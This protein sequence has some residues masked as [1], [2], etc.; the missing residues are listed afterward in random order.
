MT[1]MNQVLLADYKKSNKVRRAKLV[2]KLGFASEQEYLDH[3]E[4]KTTPPV[5]E[6]VADENEGM[7]DQVICFDTTGSMA[8]YIGAVRKHVSELIPKLFADNKNLRLKIVAFGDYCDVPG[9]SQYSKTMTLPSDLGKAYQVCELTN[10]QNK[11]IK[12]VRD[13]QNTTGGDG[14]EFYELVIKKV[15]EETSW[16]PEARKAV[17]LIAD[18]QPHD[19]KSIYYGQGK[20][21]PIDWKVEAKKS[22]EKGIAWD[23]M[24][25]MPNWVAQFYKPLSDMTGGICIPFKSSEKTQHIV[26]AATAA[27]GGERARTAFTAGAS[28]AMTSGDEELIGSYKSLSKLL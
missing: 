11:L 5:V 25:V 8:T 21:T 3:L 22:A 19:V 10:D 13:A 9:F 16:R 18:C 4:G 23:T 26:A 27:R 12:F 1:K 24:T 20:M 7:L 6:S 28:A 2:T 15:V 17:L 14:D